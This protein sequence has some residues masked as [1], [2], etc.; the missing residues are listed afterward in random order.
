MS[1]NIWVS[2]LNFLKSFKIES[3]TTQVHYNKKTFEN[4][5][6]FFKKFSKILVLE[7][8]SNKMMTAQTSLLKY[9]SPVLI[10]SNKDVNIDENP[11]VRS[12]YVMDNVIT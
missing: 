6:F 5:K 7:K 10:S 11:K 1:H 12:Y 8:M 3:E 4:I 2:L 9:D